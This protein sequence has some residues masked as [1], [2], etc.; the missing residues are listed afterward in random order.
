M[1]QTRSL[2]FSSGMPIRV[3]HARAAAATRKP[4]VG[5]ARHEMPSTD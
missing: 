5:Q 3:S 4:V 1:E 2:A